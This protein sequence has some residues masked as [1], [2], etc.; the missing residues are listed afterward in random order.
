MINWNVYKTDPIFT[1]LEHGKS[2]LVSTLHYVATNI[3]IYIVW[4]AIYVVWI[5][6]NMLKY[7]ILWYCHMLVTREKAN[8]TIYNFSML[9]V[10]YGKGNGKWQHQNM[11]TNWINFQ[12]SAPTMGFLW[13]QEPIVAE[14]M[15]FQAH[16]KHYAHSSR[17]AGWRHQM[18]IF[19]AL[20]AICARNSPVPD[21]FPTQR[22]VTR[23]FD[24]TL[25]CDRINGWVNNGQ[26][27][28]LRRHR[29][30]YVVIVMWCF[31]VVR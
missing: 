8:I 22:P 27:A 23:S 20:L 11:C 10:L 28:D 5:A 16:I 15:T 13:V 6:N 3:N 29:T 12:S 25:I 7:H 1:G 31:I 21:E 18:E 30:H 4:V 17:F 19:S 9:I 24:H 14:N 2:S 26:A